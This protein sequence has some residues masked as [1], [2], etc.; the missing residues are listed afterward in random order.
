MAVSIN[1]KMGNFSNGIAAFSKRIPNWFMP[2]LIAV[3]IFA[4]ALTFLYP[5]YKE[6]PMDDA[7]IHFV[8]AENLAE[9]G[10]LFFSF[11]DEKG[12]ATSSFL[13]VVLLAAG[14]IVG[15]PVH[16]TAKV[17]GVVSLIVVAV[18]V[19]WLLR[20]VWTPLRA[21]AAALLLSLSGNMLWFSLN[22]METTLFLAL[23]ILTLLSYRAGRWGWLGFLLGFLTLTRPE[24]VFLI[25]ALGLVEMVAYGRP[26]R[27]FVLAVVFGLLICAPWF[28]YLKWRTGSFLPT[29]A[30]AKQFGSAVATNFLLKEYHLPQFLGYFS[31]LMYPAMWIAYLLEFGL[32]GMALPPP[33]LTMSSV[34]GNPGVDISVWAIPASAI[35]IW[36]MY[37]A[38]KRFF[39][40]PKWKIWLLDPRK[41]EIFILFVWAVL[42]NLAYMIMLPIPGTA[43]RYGAINYIILWVAIVAAF[44]SLTR[45]PLRRV[46]VGL[47]LL[48]IA[49]ANNLYW[50]RVYDAN[51][52]HMLNARIAAAHFVRE[53]FSERDQCA[54]FDV[55]SLRY[56]SQ[57]PL[58]E[59]AALID[60]Q[61]GAKF[62]AGGA[63]DYMIEHGV[64]CLV[65][66]GR[67]GQQSE[68]LLDFASIMGLTTSPLF[69][70]ELVKVFEID[71]DRWLLG[72]LPTVNYQASVTIYRLK[73]K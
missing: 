66:P 39:K 62:F 60:P 2:T 8:Y 54:A 73:L 18:G 59:I 40:F 55:G 72:Y 3:A 33:K 70:M 19:Y 13:W 36:L 17:L 22:G 71:H 64:T 20:P 58:V 37:L 21:G 4:S 27:G 35:V 44:S 65:L 69:D 6:F 38:G 29:S 24:G 42:H 47:T 46:T 61:S 67:T 14:F 51:I 11:P 25:T 57:R 63:D 23:G 49:I 5:S 52:E 43:S 12:V 34:A 45:I 10:E 28:G 48:V 31:N 68:G 53:T 41:R 56:Y 15:I 32:G 26:R 1:E 7:Y 9:H 16:L 50:N 30:S